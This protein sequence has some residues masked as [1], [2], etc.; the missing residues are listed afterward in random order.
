M[1]KRV[2]EIK[3][4]EC[5]NYDFECIN[6]FKSR[7]DQVLQDRKDYG[8]NLYAHI[9]ELSRILYDYDAL[10]EELKLEKKAIRALIEDGQLII[11]NNEKEFMIV[12]SGYWIIISF[13]RL[14]RMVRWMKPRAN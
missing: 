7:L 1:E 11:K 9:D 5:Y 10:W 6:S 3:D 12:G 2:W 8:W 4:N 14:D 13:I